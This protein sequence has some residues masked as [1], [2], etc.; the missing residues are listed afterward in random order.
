[1]ESF[2]VGDLLQEVEVAL[3]SLANR[4]SNRTATRTTNINRYDDIILG[5]ENML[6]RLAVL[7]PLI[8]V[9]FPGIVQVIQS[10]RTRVK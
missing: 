1:M 9:E 2:N 6:Q 5:I 4:I 3:Y 10:V 8:S 7:Q